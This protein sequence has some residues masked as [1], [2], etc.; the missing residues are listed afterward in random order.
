[1]THPAL[2][3]AAT[4][5]WTESQVDRTGRDAIYEAA[6]WG[7]DARIQAEP[8][9]TLAVIQ[10]WLDRHHYAV[11]IDGPDRRLRGCAVATRG[12]GVIFIDAD[13]PSDE[14]DFTIAHEV[15]HLILDY[16]R[17][18]QT[19]AELIGDRDGLVFDG[20]DSPS[21]EQDI[22]AALRGR[23]LRPF[24]HLLARDVNRSASPAV[25]AREHLADELAC[26]LLAPMSD[27]QCH[28][29]TGQSVSDV[30]NLL[31]ESYRIPRGPAE[32]YARR[33]VTRFVPVPTFVDWLED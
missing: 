30:T 14:R 7:V 32:D 10:R 6:H 31:R 19:M 28:L 12:E 33:L 15:G 3:T 22:A 29:R 13:D 18:R 21:L 16:F 27:V 24:V 8:M 25:L 2:V 17:P 9:L 20:I 23:S 5:F 26:E 11:T 1:M 4:T